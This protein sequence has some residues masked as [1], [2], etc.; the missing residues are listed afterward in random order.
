MIL[1]EC[2]DEIFLCNQECSEAKDELKMIGVMSGNGD[3]ESTFIRSKTASQSF[4]SS[5]PS[6][7]ARSR[8]PG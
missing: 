5:I 8:L 4:L 2:D 7:Q 6:S 3:G 1:E